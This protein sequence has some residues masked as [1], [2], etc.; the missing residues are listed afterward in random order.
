M[1]LLSGLGR[2]GFIRLGTLAL[3]ICLLTL[4]WPAGD[5]SSSRTVPSITKVVSC[6]AG[7]A[8]GG[9][10]VGAAYDPSTQEVYVPF[11]A[12]GGGN[13]SVLSSPCNVTAIISLP[14]G[15]DP[16]AIAYNPLNHEMYVPDL[17]LDQV[18]LIAGSHLVS[19]IK[20]QFNAPFGIAFDPSAGVMVVANNG[21]NDLTLIKNATAST[22]HIA[23]GKGPSWI[24][25]DPI[26]K[27]LLVTN[28]LSGNVTTI[29]AAHLHKGTHGAIAVGSAPDAVAFDPH[30][31][32]DYVTVYS[33]NNVSE[34]NG[35]GYVQATKSI[36]GPVGIAYS[37]R[38]HLMFVLNSLHDAVWAIGG[39]TTNAKFRI[40]SG[41]GLLWGVCYDP[42]NGDMYVVGSGNSYVY[43]LR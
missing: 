21:A 26:Y 13:V 1:R 2:P 7:G 29:D 12:P 14:P 32:L 37:P 9:Y 40:G 4:S 19:T 18:Y 22:S 16:S 23:V 6:W 24:A 35:S 10:L 43:V 11:V 25:F 5:A 38:A 15:S 34:L 39:T 42:F 33:S 17:Q 20:G 28:Q 30:D 31:G 8:T 27:L 3:V 36:R 41:A